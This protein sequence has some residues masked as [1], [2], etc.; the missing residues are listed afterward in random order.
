MH[1][2]LIRKKSFPIIE[3]CDLCECHTCIKS[4][5]QTQSFFLRLFVQFGRKKTGW[6]SVLGWAQLLL[7]DLEQRRL[8]TNSVFFDTCNGTG[9]L[10]L[11]CLWSLHSQW[12]CECSFHAHSLYLAAHFSLKVFQKFIISFGR[13]L[14]DIAERSTFDMTGLT[15]VATVT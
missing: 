3:V 10:S 11:P 15:G 14:A 1:Q 5:V 13:L 7:S 6:L 12:Y 4:V 9:K 2:K 8:N